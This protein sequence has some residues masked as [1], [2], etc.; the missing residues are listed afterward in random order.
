M[1][2]RFSPG[3]ISKKNQTTNVNRYKL[4]SVLSSTS[5]NGQDMK[6]PKWTMETWG[7]CVHIHIYTHTHTVGYHSAKTR[8]KMLP[9]AATWMDLEVLW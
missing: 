8:N 1:I 7:V 4:P 2:R 3:R 5:L 9:F 6:R